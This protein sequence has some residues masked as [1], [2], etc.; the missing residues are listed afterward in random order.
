MRKASIKTLLEYTPYDNKCPS[1]FGIRGAENEEEEKFYTNNLFVDYPKDCESFREKLSEYIDEQTIHLITFSG[2]SGSGKTT[3]LKNFFRN[4]KEYHCKYINLVEY[5]SALGN[6]ETVA[7]T[8]KSGLKSLLTRSVAKTLYETY[9]DWDNNRFEDVLLSLFSSEERTLFMSFCESFSQYNSSLQFDNELEKFSFYHDDDLTQLLSLYLILSIIPYKQDNDRSF[10]FVFDNLD[11]VD[12]QYISSSLRSAIN[13]AYSI[14][15]T[16]CEKVLQYNFTWNVT[17]LLSVRKENKRY[18]RV[19]DIQERTDILHTNPASMEFSQ[20]Y[21]APYSDILN[22]RLSYYENNCR[23]NKSNETNIKTNYD[24]IKKLLHSEEVFFRRF[25]KPLYSY[26][27]RMFTHF[28]I[29]NL[30]HERTVSVPEPLISPDAE[31]DCHQGARGMLLFYSLAG[32]LGYDISRFSSYVK[33]EFSGDTCNIFRMSF[34]L[35]SNLSGWAR[36]NEELMVLLEDEDD[37]NGTTKQVEMPEFLDTIGA[38]YK[39]EKTTL[40]PKVLNGLIGTSAN[41]FE[42]PILLFGSA[43]DECVRL[44][45]DKFSVAELAAKVVRDYHDD[46]NSLE[47][48]TIQI[49]P[50]CIVYSAR[51]FIHYEYFNLISTQWDNVALADKKERY[52]PKP[53]FQLTNFE[54]DT[55]EISLCLSCTFETAKK[56][57]ETAD[58]H[59]CKRCRSKYDGKCN[60]DCS[61]SIK[62]FKEDGFCFNNTIHATRI[63]SAHIHYLE[64]YRHFLWYQFGNKENHS[65]QEI[66]IQKI[67]IEQIMKYIE[68]YKNRELKD[69]KYK[70]ITN[71]WGSQFDNALQNLIDQPQKYTE[72]TLTMRSE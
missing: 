52:I 55:D 58:K 21:Q 9:K 63:I 12:K 71:Y 70:P 14:A 51:V 43:I 38:W 44:L 15:Q 24:G 49:N 48:V 57:I 5:P 31:N 20:E 36:R 1:P 59:F 32:L 56:I 3:F 26:D 53:L 13:S 72:I 33:E 60:K 42:C 66:K 54:K 69:D 41:S 22:A 62:K 6:Y 27:Y 47:S 68:F 7:T 17:F 45:K 64:H 25:I 29:S 4:K 18:L 35:L 23:S 10:V 30:L 16:Y 46:F 28:A 37:F 19:S 65:E 61:D 40:I 2:S 50:L 11:E 34:T 39:K 67:I 8:L